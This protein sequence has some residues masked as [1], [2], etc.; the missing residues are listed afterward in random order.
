MGII[1]TLQGYKAKHSFKKDLPQMRARQKHCWGI[2]D[3]YTFFIA[4]VNSK[5][6][7][8]SYGMQNIYDHAIVN[9]LEQVI[10]SERFEPYLHE[11]KGNRHLAFEL[12]AFNM[13]VSEAFL[14]PLHILEIAMRNRFNLVLSNAFGDDWF[15]NPLIILSATQQKQLEKARADILQNSK[16]INTA[17]LVSTLTFGFW[18][19]L[20]SPDLE[21]LWHKALHKAISQENGKSLKMKQLRKPL[22]PIRTLRNRIAHHEPV[23]YWDLAKHYENILQVTRWLSPIAADWSEYHSRF[24]ETWK[25][26]PL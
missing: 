4:E 2:Q 26:K 19:T 22:I 17:R 16:Q 24:N 21:N 15:T 1:W 18:T 20:L 25:M 7:K 12:Y 5:V 10:S 14:T 8:E 9:G 13:Q 23:W 3:K 6:S 11:T